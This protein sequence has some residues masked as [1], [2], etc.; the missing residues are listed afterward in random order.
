MTVN[1]WMEFSEI[2]C[3]API[4][5]LRSRCQDSS[6]H[7]CSSLFSWS[8]RKSVL[9]LCIA[10]LRVEAFIV[11]SFLILIQQL[12]GT[13]SCLFDNEVNKNSI[14]IFFIQLINITPDTKSTRTNILIVRPFPSTVTTNTFI[15]S[16]NQC[17]A[18]Q[19][20]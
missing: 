4:S 1:S 8:T 10:H 14:S 3:E 11:F 16:M 20:F 7:F 15:S 6:Y 12:V 13:K 5:C 17:C 9:C 19:C 18:L 2:D